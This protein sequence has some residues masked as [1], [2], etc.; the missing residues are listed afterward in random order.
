MSY[1]AKGFYIFEKGSSFRRKAFIFR[2]FSYVGDL[3]WLSWLSRSARG[4]LRGDAPGTNF[5]RSGELGQ[6]REN[7]IQINLFG[8]FSVCIVDVQSTLLCFQS[9]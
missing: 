1:V 8:E 6:H 9:N 7:P 4:Q 5:R 3:E 2:R